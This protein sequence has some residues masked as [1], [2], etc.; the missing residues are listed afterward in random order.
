MV[1]ICSVV[2]EEDDDYV[3]QVAGNAGLRDQ[4]LALHWVAENI[5]HFGGDPNRV[6]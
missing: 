2:G 5:A 4:A 3:F 1:T 6:S